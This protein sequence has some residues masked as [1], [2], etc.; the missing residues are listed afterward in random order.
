MKKIEQVAHRVNNFLSDA[1]GIRIRRDRDEWQ[2]YDKQHEQEALAAV[3]TIEKFNGQTLLPRQKNL[4]DE[5]S[6]KILGNKAY[7]PWLYVYTLVSGG[8]FKEGWIPDNFF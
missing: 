1:I 2:L 7:A 3:R 5:Y 4:A 8:N 6:I